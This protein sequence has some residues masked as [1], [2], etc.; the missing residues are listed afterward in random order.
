MSYVNF[1]DEGACQHLG[2]EEPEIKGQDKCKKR[3]LGLMCFGCCEVET[4]LRYLFLKN[5]KAKCM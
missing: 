1:M 5:A 4:P 2:L 3:W